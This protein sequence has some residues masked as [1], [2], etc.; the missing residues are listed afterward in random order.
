MGK[1]L[2]DRQLVSGHMVQHLYKHILG[3]PVVF[4]DLERVDEE[5]YNSLKQLVDLDKNGEDLSS[6]MLDFTTTTEVLGQ[7]DEIEMVKGGADMEVNNDNFPEY[8]EACLKYRMLDRVKTQLT[9]LLLGF[10]D[11]IPE[12]L[13]TIF[14]FQEL[15]L[16]MC[17]MPEIDIEDWKEHT[18]YSGEYD[19]TGGDH[20]V[21]QWF[22][23]VVGELDR[24]MKARLLQFVTGMYLCAGLCMM[25]FTRDR[26]DKVADITVMPCINRNVGSASARFWCVTGQ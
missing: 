2:F 17:G 7:K 18:E 21:C 26:L 25:S 16:L 8:L 4:S 23:E 3:W 12:P 1:A 14:D 15:E 19:H 13:L 6:L 11:V 10:F 9:E 22:W 5:Y 24:E 20:E